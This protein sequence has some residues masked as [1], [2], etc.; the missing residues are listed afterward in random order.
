MALGDH[1]QS[2]L[3]DQIIAAIYGRA[4]VENNDRDVSGARTH[5]LPI[6]KPY[7]HREYTAS[8]IYNLETTIML[9]RI[10][11]QNSCEI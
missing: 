9:S 8:G 10:K 2:K 4:V 6:V 7:D 3:M 11:F 1:D 5:D